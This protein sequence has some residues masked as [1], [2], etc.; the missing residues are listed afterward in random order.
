MKTINPRALISRRGSEVKVWL[1]CED[2]PTGLDRVQFSNPEV[3]VSFFR[4]HVS[5]AHWFDPEKEA[6]V[7]FCL[8]RKN[9]IKCWNLVSLGSATSTVCAPREVFRPAI[10][11]SATAVVILHNHPSGDPA[12]SAHDVILTRELLMAAGVIGIQVLDHI[13]VGAPD[14]DPQGRGFFSMAGARPGPFQNR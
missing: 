4:E 14:R 11:A 1:V 7:V 6:M 12:P 8:D 13:I 5:A 3:A 2:A 10:V 9:Q